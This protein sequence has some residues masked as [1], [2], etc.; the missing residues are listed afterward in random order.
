MKQQ[1]NI[2]I[3]GYGKMGKAIEKTA[4]ARDHRIT[5]I[6]DNE[7]DWETK[8]SK[9]KACD[10]AIEFTTP[11]TAAENIQKCFECGVPVVS[12]TTG[13][14]NELPGIKKQCLEQK[15]T[16]FHA[17]N[18]SIGV[19]VFFALNKKLA[20][21]LSDMEGYHPKII[22]THHTEKLDAPSGT[23][24]TL[25]KEIINARRSLDRW[26]DASEKPASNVLPIK[27]YRIEN[28]TGTHVVTYSSV[29]DNIEIK[30]TSH[31]RS[32]FA[33][34]AILAAEWLQN[35][36]GVFTMQDMLKL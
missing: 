32:G 31:T 25:A 17:S 4:L 2:A 6:I 16:F 36:E 30:H 3:I 26:G 5:L 33:E 7:A 15:G 34:G 12:G 19:N 21:M 18:F 27:S 29:I 22:E 35:K 14:L 24:I 20:G 1:L 8:I 10:A 9:L 23:A 28:I 11:A 13:W